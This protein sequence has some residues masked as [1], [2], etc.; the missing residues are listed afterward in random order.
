MYP[1]MI[2]R[3][4]LGCEK[5]RSTPCLSSK[6]FGC[7]VRTLLK[8]LISK[9]ILEPKRG[10]WRNKKNLSSFR[11]TLAGL[12]PDKAALLNEYDVGRIKVYGLYISKEEVSL[13]SD[14][15]NLFSNLIFVQPKTLNYF[16][17]ISQCIKLSARNEIFRFLNVKNSDIGHVSS[18]ST[19]AKITAPIIYPKSFYRTKKWRSY[20]IVHDVR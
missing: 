7:Y 14:E 13:S 11:D 15:K 6:T 2:T 3:W 1:P 8:H 16:Q 20:C 10:V 5:W 19:D 17:W 18:S 4:L 9:S 12:F